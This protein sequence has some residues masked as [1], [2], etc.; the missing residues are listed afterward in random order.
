[1]DI[2]SSRNLPNGYC[3]SVQLR[4]RHVKYLLNGFWF[5]HAFRR[6]TPEIGLGRFSSR[7]RLHEQSPG[8]FTATWALVAWLVRKDPVCLSG[9]EKWEGYA[10]SVAAN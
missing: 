7:Y 9:R 2:L 1:M 5:A 8:L 4:P 6:D 3:L 10:T